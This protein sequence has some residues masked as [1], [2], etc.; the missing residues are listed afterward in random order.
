[1]F[2]APLTAML[3]L[4]VPIY[5]TLFVLA[6]PLVRQVL[7]DSCAGLTIVVQLLAIDGIIDLLTDA[8]KPMLRGQA[9]PRTDFAF[10]AVRTF[11]LI[12]L[13]IAPRTRSVWPEPP[14]P[15]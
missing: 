4:L 10:T 3:S 14:G 5:A 8:L 2:K 7:P 11:L 1:M 6:G 15:G 13:A 9:R 12:G